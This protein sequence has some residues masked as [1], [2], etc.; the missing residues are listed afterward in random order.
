MD[1]PVTDGVTVPCT[2][3]SRCPAPSTN[4]GLRIRGTLGHHPVFM[5]EISPFA[6]AVYK[7]EGKCRLPLC[8]SLD[9]S[10]KPA[11][12]SFL[13]CVVGTVILPASWIDRRIQ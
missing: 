6:K 9:K 2:D 3:P 10:S 13:F 8:V 1:T 4:M 11:S 7:T 12:L 5:A